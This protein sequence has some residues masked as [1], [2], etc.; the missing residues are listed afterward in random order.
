MIKL[1][2][3]VGYLRNKSIKKPPQSFIIKVP[4]NEECSGEYSEQL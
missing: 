3:L 4:T 2:E 1:I